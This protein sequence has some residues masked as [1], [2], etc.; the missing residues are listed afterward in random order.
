MGRATGYI[1]VKYYYDA[2]DS[3]R[4]EFLCCNLLCIAVS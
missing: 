4:F 1:I 3:S 2:L